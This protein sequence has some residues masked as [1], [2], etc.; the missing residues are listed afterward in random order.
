[1]AGKPLDV[2]SPNH[3]CWRA[4][5]AQ[6]EL[7]VQQGPPPFGEAAPDRAPLWS[8]RAQKPGQ[9]NAPERL[10]RPGI[11]QGSRN[12]PVSGPATN[13]RSRCPS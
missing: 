3:H 2:V 7:T 4:I 6:S 8:P 12:R 9:T 1:M 11:D 13:A 10:G 5:R